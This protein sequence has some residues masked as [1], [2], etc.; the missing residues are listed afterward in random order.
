MTQFNNSLQNFLSEYY[1]YSHF[2]ITQKNLCSHTTSNEIIKNIIIIISIIMASNTLSETVIFTL[3]ID[4]NSRIYEV[5][6]LQPNM[7][8]SL[9]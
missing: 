7:R 1:F 6:H 5:G 8:F 4:F 2:S 3:I 9:V